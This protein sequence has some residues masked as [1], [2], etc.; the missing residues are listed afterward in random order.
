MK[1]F[2]LRILL[3]TKFVFICRQRTPNSIDRKI[4]EKLSL[5]KFWSRL[6]I[7]RASGENSVKSEASIALNTTD[8][9][10]QGIAACI[11]QVKFSEM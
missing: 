7:V 4:L 8:T 9:Y 10:N 5:R 2:Q 6:S 3:C 11:T 1:P